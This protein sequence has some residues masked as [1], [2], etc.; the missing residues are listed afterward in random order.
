VRG[1]YV[2]VPFCVRKCGYCDFYSLA[3][4]GES[5]SAYVEAVVREAS[6]RGRRSF[7]T[8]YLGG[9]T[10]SLLGPELLEK[11]VAGLWTLFDMSGVVEASMEVNPDSAGRALL[12]SARKIGINR[13]SVGIQS[14]ADDELKGVG[15]IH[16]ASQAIET[17]RLAQE[18]GFPSVSADLIVGLPG[19]TQE[20]L[21][22][23]VEGIIDLG[24]DHV[25]VYCLSIEE[26]TP[27]AA[28]I[29][30]NLPSDDTQAELFD[31]AVH[32]LTGHGFDHYEISNFARRGHE[33][34]HNLVYW[35]GDEY[36]G[37]GPAA[38]SH[39]DGRRFK[40]KAD[41][42]TYIVEPAGQTEQV[43]QL[44]STEKA[45]EEAML[46]LRLL[47]EGLDIEALIAR[48]GPGHVT[49][50]K[51][52]LDK[53]ADGGMLKRTGTRYVLDAGRVLTSNLIFAEVIS[54]G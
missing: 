33:C 50:L 46:R 16:T 14:L 32:L 53:L 52:R 43:E 10:P 1:L 49:A 35:H 54:P 8:L 12:Q 51:G 25:S 34:L 30:G 28:S 47:K 40:N 15:R 31:T 22:R 23:S 9:G 36:V 18:V 29:P 24:L 19:Q 20:S 41:L 7:Q 26:G 17:V 38:A 42:D 48:F 44:S 3:G 4:R 37:L 13:V 21:G 2:H 45:S 39:I 11:L 6:A 27:L 5:R